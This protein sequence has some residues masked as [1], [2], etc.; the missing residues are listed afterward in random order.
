MISIKLSIIQSINS[1]RSKKPSLSR[2]SII[3]LDEGGNWNN[4]KN[5]FNKDRNAEGKWIWNSVYE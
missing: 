2:I 5:K 1:N 4:I 3:G